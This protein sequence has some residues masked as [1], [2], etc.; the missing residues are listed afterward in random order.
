MD[1]LLSAE[2]LAIPQVSKLIPH[3]SYGGDY[4]PEQWTED[5]WLEDARFMKAAG[6]NLVSLGIFSWGK[7]EPRDGEYDF[8]WLDRVIDILHAHDI[9]INLATATASTPAWF[10]RKYPDS[11]PVEVDGTRL[12]FGSRQHYCPNHKPLKAYTEKLVRTIATRYKD[13]PSLKMWHINNEYGCHVSRCYCDNCAA[14]FRS[15]LKE[16]YGSIEELNARWG[17]RFWSQQ[18]GEWEEVQPP[19]KAPTFCNPGQQLDYFRFMNDSLLNLYLTEKQIL[20]EITPDVPISTNFMDFFKPLDYFRWAKEVDVATWDSY[21]DPR[22]GLPVR[23]SMMHD[24]MRSL[25]KGQPFFLMEQVTSQVNWR[26][27]NMNKAPGVMRLWSYSAIGH[28]GDGILFFQWR[29]SRAGAEKFHGGMIPHSNDE[30][31]RIY[32][33]V[34]ELGQELK[35]L[36]GLIG[37]R[38][39]AKV[40]IIFDWENWWAVEL[41]SKPHNDLPYVQRVAAYYNECFKR[42]IAV[43]FVQPSDDLTSYEIVIA[44]MLYMIKPGEAEN[45]ENYVSG[46][47]TLIVSYFSG[48]VDENDRFYPGAFPAPLRK[49]LGIKVEE[50]DPYPNGHANTVAYQ[51]QTF[52][53]SLW[54]DVIQLEG[55]DAIA[56][57]T[58]HWY[59]GRPA[60]TSY[61]FGTG[62][63]VYIGT[64]LDTECLGALLMELITEKG[65]S[66]PLLAPENV[67]VLQ[68]DTDQNKHL[69]IINHNQEDVRL[70]LP[71]EQDYVNLLSG[72]RVKG[73]I[74]VSGIDVAV[75]QY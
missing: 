10:V 15:W 23:A 39:P 13:H 17:T 60:V 63:S 7:I 45:L 59:A 28:G 50:F 2:A 55:A 64:E 43:D 8:S 75:L 46:G 48:I 27:I 57:Y 32:R 58:G 34:K 66:A 54:S 71:A 42:N 65:I 25:R 33:E 44:P 62:K 21:P 67:E 73:S 70:D 11:L 1:Q 20:R 35:K 72:E 12:S 18:Y 53:C 3:M 4:N 74:T 19:R 14:A 40:A 38:T 52:A 41:D 5:I 61:S 16:R 49:L 24:L 6:V 56:T 36:D 29:Q 22:E 26:D 68:R 31:S 47:G 69:L 9:G 51:G 30:N 37:A